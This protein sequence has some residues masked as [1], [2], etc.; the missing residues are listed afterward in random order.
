ME[1]VFIDRVNFKDYGKYYEVSD[2]GKVYRIDTGKELT[3]RINN[4]YKNVCV[5][6]KDDGTQN[7]V[8]VHRL[9][10]LTFIPNSDPLK[11]INVNH[12]DEN[13]LNNNSKNLEWVTQGENCN[14][15][16]QKISHE[17]RVIQKD[18]KGNFI[19][20]FNSVTEAGDSMGVTRHAIN[21]VCLGKNKTSAGFLWEYEDSAYKNVEVDL[22]QAKSLQDVFGIYENYYVFKDGK[23]YN[24]RNKLFLKHCINHKGVHYV[25]LPP[26]TPDKKG[27]NEY[28]HRLVALCFIPNPENKKNIRHIDGNKDDNSVENIEWWY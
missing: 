10:A 12:I 1:I 22:N 9:V 7:D 4:G 25:S 23:V 3:V 16:S 5:Q 28:V 15:H 24:K 2:T 8:A 20:V 13:K 6:N 19:K 18:L 11:K 27:K 17:H 14:K 21:K 26:P